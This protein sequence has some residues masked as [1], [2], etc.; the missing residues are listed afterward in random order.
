MKKAGRLISG[1]RIR[2]WLRGSDL[3]WRPSGYEHANIY[4]ARWFCR[5][6]AAIYAN[7]LLSQ[8]FPTRCRTNRLPITGPRQ[9]RNAWPVPVRS[10]KLLAA[11][12]GG[13][14]GGLESPQRPAP[15]SRNQSRPHQLHF[16][17][18]FVSCW[19]HLRIQTAFSWLPRLSQAH[20]VGRGWSPHSSVCP[21][22]RPSNAQPNPCKP[23]ILRKN[24]LNDWANAP[25]PIVR[26]RDN[27]HGWGGQGRMPDKSDNSRT[28]FS[29]TPTTR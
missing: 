26:Q 29:C 18:F 8:I 28:G 7:L 23:C 3:N 2:N 22:V 5:D 27:P 12:P 20:K 19:D 4:V 13:Y 17:F 9:Q 24:R 14:P 16:S 25:T 11:I 21:R 6:L 1:L 10:Q 15:P